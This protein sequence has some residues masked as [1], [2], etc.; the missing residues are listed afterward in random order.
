MATVEEQELIDFVDWVD[1]AVYNNVLS[2]VRG[3]SSGYYKLWAYHPYGQDEVKYFT[4]IYLLKH[5]K[6]KK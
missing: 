1:D 5:F 6:G 2:R 4:T 3:H